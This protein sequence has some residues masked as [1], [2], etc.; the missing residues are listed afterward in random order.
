MLL[1]ACGYATSATCTES[2]QGE[3]SFDGGMSL[4]MGGSGVGTTTE[5][6][7]RAIV[8]AAHTGQ[9]ATLMSGLTHSRTKHARI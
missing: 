9:F 1:E 3:R 6:A 2:A 8:R 7:V 4:A 5:G